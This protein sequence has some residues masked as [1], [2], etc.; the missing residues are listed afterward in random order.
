MNRNLSYDRLFCLLF[1]FDQLIQLCFIHKFFL[2]FDYTKSVL[3]LG[4]CTYIFV[5]CIIRVT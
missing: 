2:S 1:D 5:S 4:S 3:Y